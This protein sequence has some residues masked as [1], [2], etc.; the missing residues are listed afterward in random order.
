MAVKETIHAKGLDIAIFTNDYNEYAY[1]QVSMTIMNSI[2]TENREYRPLETI[3]DNYPK[4]VFTR[5][6][7][8]QRRNGIKHVNMPEFMKNGGVFV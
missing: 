1:A 4:Y 7:P 6:D 3:E 8:I 5:N 2:E